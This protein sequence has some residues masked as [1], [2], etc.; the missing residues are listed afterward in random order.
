MSFVVGVVEQTMNC[1]ISCFVE[2]C[3]NE[4]VLGCGLNPPWLR[5]ILDQSDDYTFRED[6]RAWRACLVVRLAMYVR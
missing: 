2:R 6:L 4:Y 1:L 3:A 5:E